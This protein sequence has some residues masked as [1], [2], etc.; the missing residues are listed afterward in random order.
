MATYNSIK[1]AS[2]AYFAAKSRGDAAG[3]QAAND[4][5]NAIRAANGEAPHYAGEDIAAVARKSASS[6]SGT[7][8]RVVSSGST[9]S[10]SRS[11]GG[12]GS[13]VSGGSSGSY[14]G[15]GTSGS[16]SSVRSSGSSGS[17]GVNLDIQIQQAMANGA[18]TSYVQNLV[19]QRY[20]KIAA[21]GGALDQYKNDATMQAAWNYINQANKG[22]GGSGGAYVADGRVYQTAQGLGYYGNDPTLQA[23]YDNLANLYNTDKVGYLQTIY[24]RG[25]GGAGNSMMPNMGRD[26]S[27]AGKVV[28]KGNYAVYYDENGYA[29]KAVKMGNGTSVADLNANGYYTG[30]QRTWAD[31][32]GGNLYDVY[33]QSGAGIF[34][35]G[36]QGAGAAGSGSS[37]GGSR[38]TATLPNGQT[39]T[40]DY[41]GGKVQSS[42]PVGSIVHTNGGD[43]IVTGGTPG[44]YTSERYNGTTSGGNTGGSGQTLTA[45]L[46]S[47]QT[48]VVDY[49]NGKVLSDI[50][51][52]SIVH[53][54]AGDYVVTGGTPGN[55]TSDRYTGQPIQVQDTTDYA[56]LI[57]VAIN[58]G[59]SWQEVQNLLDLRNQKI[60]SDPSLQKYMY[61][62]Y[63]V[64]AMQY[65]YTQQQNELQLEATLASLRGAY[66]QSR[67][68]Y[69]NARNQI[70]PVYQQQRNATAATSDVNWSA[71]NE[72]AAA[73]GLN[74]GAVGQAALS[75]AVA[76]QNDLNEL[77]QSEAEELSAIDLEIAQLEA[78][79]R[80]AIA[81]AQ[82]EGDAELA[83]QLY[84][85]FNQF[86]DAKN[87]RT[88]Q[89]QAAQMQ[90]AQ[91]AQAAQE[92]AYDQVMEILSY[93]VMPSAELLAAAGMDEAT[94]RAIYNRVVAELGGSSSSGG[95]GSRSS[96]SGGKSSAGSSSGSSSGSSAAGG[97]SSASGGGY[98][99]GSVSASQVRQMQNFLGVSTDGK[100]GSASS[101]AAGGM[102]ADE[103]WSVFSALPSDYQSGVSYLERNGRDSAAGG[104]MTNAEWA[105]HRNSGN[106]ASGASAYSTYPEYV[107]AYTFA[108]MIG[109]V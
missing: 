89:A 108:A 2:D 97:G 12:S 77:N 72:V 105:R 1:E 24:N 22:T 5:A 10:G 46:P 8:S 68:G 107:R 50:P 47:G 48:V 44:N 18:S 64:R 55:Y 37:G 57:N 90:A 14:S 61:D 9:G 25:N 87:N 79:Y 30:A 16:G 35:G 69:E 32:T 75:R 38:M 43:Y 91:D 23:Y 74:T 104:L 49:A 41:A 39:V 67:A 33:G 100:W 62:E 84:D 4:A 29:V 88:Q 3:M 80:S 13:I 73:N 95:S 11:T 17:G 53:T 51:V 71:F 28:A 96:G 101:A 54:A 27:L 94:A 58:S 21:A 26:P 42:I 92:A 31:V 81:Q 6:S 34:S 106:D 15:S 70:A 63:Y 109:E 76:L 65:I 20:D 52:G 19:N 40:V 45:T 56:H 103:A 98:N 85:Q 86:I 59:A 36:A 99:N 102:S 60:A 7:G 82:R 66:E 83:A 78:E 93:G